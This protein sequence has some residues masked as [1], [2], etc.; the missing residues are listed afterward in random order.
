MTESEFV[1]LA[2][3]K[4][5]RISV[6]GIFRITNQVGGQ[7]EVGV[8]EAC[9]CKRLSGR[10]REVRK[11]NACSDENSRRAVALAVFVNG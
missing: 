10:E 3:S 9:T 11:Q 4:V 6:I 5:L 2:V 7:R 8:P 1:A